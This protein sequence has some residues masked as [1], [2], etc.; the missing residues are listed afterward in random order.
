MNFCHGTDPVV[1]KAMTDRNAHPAFGYFEPR[2]EYFHD[3]IIRWHTKRNGGPGADERRCI[4]Y[5]N[6][7]SAVS[8][9]ALNVS[10]SREIK[11][12]VDRRPTSDLH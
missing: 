7:V 3:A 11:V 8:L 6:G 9:S 12:L 1:Q 2:E 10:A 4:G 5:E